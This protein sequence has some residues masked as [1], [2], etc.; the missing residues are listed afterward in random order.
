MQLRH[1]TRWMWSESLAALE[2]A[3]RL[4]SQFCRL[5]ETGSGYPNREPPGDLF[6]TVAQAAA[7]G[8]YE[9]RIELPLR[10]MSPG[11]SSHRDGCRLLVFDKPGSS[12]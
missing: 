4:Q 12:L 8:Q 1:P 2:R 11:Q 9:R 7:Y 3:D 6:E 10:P 5:G